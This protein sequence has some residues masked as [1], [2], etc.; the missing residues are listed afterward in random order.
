M[1]KT[2][3]NVFVNIS[4]RVKWKYRNDRKKLRKPLLSPIAIEGSLVVQLA[5]LN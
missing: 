1:L 3:E 5:A 2:T 4:V